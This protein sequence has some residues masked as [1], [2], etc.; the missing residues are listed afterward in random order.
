MNS[1]VIIGGIGGSGTRVVAAIMRGAGIYLGSDLNVPL[2]NLSYTLLFKNPKWFYKN[3]N[4]YLKFKPGLNVIEKLLTG[5]GY[6]NPNE[7]LFILSATCRMYYNGHN[8]NNDGRGSWA[9]ERMRKILFREKVNTAD[10]IGWGWKEPNSH[11]I[12]EHLNRRFANMKFIYTV[13]NGLDMAFSKN[14]QQF[15]NWGA[16]FGIPKPTNVNELPKLSFKYWVA[17]NKRIKGLQQQLGNEKV[18]VLNFD[19]LY[20]EP[21]KEIHKLFS[22]AGISVSKS[23]FEK[24]IKLPVKP[25]SAGRYKDFDVSGF[26]E[27]DIAF[28]NT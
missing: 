18:Y 6:Y 2:D 9:V 19:N 5:E 17:V 10:Y 1:P 22:F 21:E 11:L 4:N 8:H 28:F 7:L 3:K 14:Q 27:K 23:T 24:I 12:I 13:R 20:K 25:K 15:Y 26:D 16:M